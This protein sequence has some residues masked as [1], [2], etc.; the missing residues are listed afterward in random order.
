M[1]NSFYA[2]SAKLF[3]IFS[4]S[5]LAFHS[6]QAETKA[7]AEEFKVQLRPASKAE[8]AAA[9]KPEESADEPKVVVDV[10]A[11]TE[12]PKDEPKVVSD[13]KKVVAEKTETPADPA[14]ALEFN[15]DIRTVDNQTIYVVNGR[16]PH[17]YMVT[18]DIYGNDRNWKAIAEWNSLIAPYDL[19]PGQQLVLKKAPTI[20]N[21]E[22]DK[23]LLKAWAKMD[24]WDIIKGIILAQEQGT[25]PAARV[26]MPVLPAPPAPETHSPAPEVTPAPAVQQQESAPAAHGHEGHWKFK[27]SAVLSTFRLQG[28]YNDLDIDNSL[29]SE[30]DYG[31]ELEAAYHFSEKTELIV[32][33]SVEKMDIHPPA[34]DTEIE[35]HSQYLARYS[36]GVETE[37]TPR[38]TFAGS[39]AYEQTPFAVPTSGGTEIEAIFIPQI[40]LGFRWGLLDRG[41]FKWSLI[42]D[43]ILLMQTTHEDMELKTGSGFLLG[44]KFANEFTKHT[45]TYGVSYREL[46][47]NTDESD[48]SLKSY[49]ANIGMIW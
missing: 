31:I 13:V 21:A 19:R 9:A 49:F 16:A 41:S 25:S 33:A 46:R 27:T 36:L 42:T 2:R 22:A 40:S 15:R 14:K 35:G 24:R 32:G 39:A 1:K 12:A 34:D 10:N 4:S 48:N 43:G 23:I 30:L 11:K 7:A 45:L 38:A 47:Q 44:F 37:L 5:L 28:K 3:L 8:K 20:S 6:A 18:R 17:L 29:S 26:E